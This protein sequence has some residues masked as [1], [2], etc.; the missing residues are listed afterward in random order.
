MENKNTKITP[1]LINDIFNL[2]KANIIKSEKSKTD[3]N[4]QDLEKKLADI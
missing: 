2:A 3:K 1:K 4:L